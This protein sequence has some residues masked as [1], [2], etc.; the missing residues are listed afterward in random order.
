MYLQPYLFA[1]W[2]LNTL[3]LTAV[4]SAL[5]SYSITLALCRWNN[6]FFPCNFCT[7]KKKVMKECCK[8]HPH[9][10]ELMLFSPLG[11]VLAP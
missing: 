5:Q 4:A 2:A 1:L 6:R 3:K 11:I 7:K 8:D 9:D 10:N